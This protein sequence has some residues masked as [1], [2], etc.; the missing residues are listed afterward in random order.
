VQHNRTP[1]GRH[2][3]DPKLAGRLVPQHIPSRTS[4]VSEKLVILPETE[5]VDDDQDDIEGTSPPK[6]SEIAAGKRLKGRTYAESKPKAWRAEK[7]PRVTAYGTAQS[8]KLRPTADFLKSKHGARTKLYDDCL[9]VIYQLPLL[10]GI[11]GYRIRSSPVM[12]S[13][14]GKSLLEEEIERIER[15]ERHV[16]YYDDTHDFEGNPHSPSPNEIHQN[17]DTDYSPEHHR[18]SSPIPMAQ[19]ST[20]L[21]IAEMFVFSYGVVVFWNFTER[22]ERDILGDLTF[23]KSETGIQLA[24]RPLDESDFETEEFHFEYN[25]KISR[26]RVL[27]D[28]FTLRSHDHMIKLAISHAIA[29][30]TKLSHFEERMERTMME[31]QDVP[32]T[33]ALTGS[34]GMKRED[35]VKIL[36]RLFTSRVE[37]NL[38]KMMSVFSRIQLT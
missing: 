11:D 34:L 9:Y 20:S 16:G 2:P 15:G 35:V 27:A 3:L 24:T 37:V 6:D 19:T 1:S 4:K 32:R 33:L 26:P 31:A 18:S 23:S 10:H 13:P 29:Q 28:M 7:L 38:C 17:L 22:Q 8:Y 25:P 14:G 36:G 30:S 5:R 12:I 21:S